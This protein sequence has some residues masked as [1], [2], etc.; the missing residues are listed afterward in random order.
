MGIPARSVTLPVMV[1]ISSWAYKVNENANSIN[2]IRQCFMAA[3][4]DEHKVR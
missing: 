4:F 3:G 2:L 1:S